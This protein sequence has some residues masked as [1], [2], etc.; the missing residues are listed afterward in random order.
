M[1]Q[2]GGIAQ[3]AAELLAVRAE[4]A[5]FLETLPDALVEGDLESG[6]ITQ[7]NRMARILFGYTQKDVRDGIAASRLFADGEY[8]RCRAVIDS[9]VGRSREERAPYVRSGRQE[10]YEATLRRKDGATFAT[11]TQNAFVLD[12]RGLPV[13]LRSLVRDVSDRKA[14][15]RRLAELTVRDPL[16]GCYNRRHLDSIRADLERPSVRWGCMVFDLDDFKSI[17]DRYGHDEGDRVLQR[18][19]HFVSRQ[20]RTEDIFVRLGGDE[21]GLV[22]HVDTPDELDALSMRLREAATEGSPVPFSLGVAYR[23][24]DESIEEVLIRADRTMYAMKTRD[25]V[26]AR[27]RKRSRAALRAGAAAEG[28]SR[29]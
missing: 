12:E 1:A 17:N 8:E 24:A 23:M 2:E 18:F 7:M 25:P 3:L 29:S 13:R 27:K 19:A 15:E 10:L 14:A 20:H 26:Y 21:F 6:R 5:T 4:Y 16:T 9:Y 28:G 22:V 11:E